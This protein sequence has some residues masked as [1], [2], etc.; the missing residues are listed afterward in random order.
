MN[1]TTLQAIVGI[2]TE[3]PSPGELRELGQ[4]IVAHLRH[5]S[6]YLDDVIAC[7][8]RMNSLLKRPSLQTPLSASAE[9][10]ASVGPHQQL[11]SLP[12]KAHEQL[13]KIRE[14]LAKR[15]LPLAE[16]RQT[17]QSTIHKLATIS[18]SEPTIRQLAAILDQ[19]LREELHDL[20]IEIKSKIQIVQA[21]TM[22]N[23]A[24]LLYTL[25]FYSRLMTGISGE[26][27]T[28]QGYNSHGQMTNRPQSPLIQKHC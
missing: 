10:Q 7:G 3:P 6:A 20:R 18:N 11:N 2:Q 4:A 1:S 9:R 25:D 5:E 12:A 17:M 22:G 15:F 28:N 23:Q 13:E 26:I 16:G 14:E 8:Q 19:P 27:A 24:V 21:I